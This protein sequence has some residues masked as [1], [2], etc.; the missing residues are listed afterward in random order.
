M[1]GDAC[2]QDISYMSS[3]TDFASELNKLTAGVG[4]S[5]SSHSIK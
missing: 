5:V 2:V 3:K 1:L 4:T